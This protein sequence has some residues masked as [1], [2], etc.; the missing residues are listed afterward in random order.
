MM[1][2]GWWWMGWV[3]RVEELSVVLATMML[4]L[5]L[6]YAQLTLNLLF[7]HPCVV[8]AFNFFSYWNICDPA[9][10]RDK[11]SKEGDTH[12]PIS[13]FHLNCQH[14]YENN[15]DTAFCIFSTFW[16]QNCT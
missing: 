12:H 14:A 9:Q 4:V 6:E 7:P 11:S 2:Y 13:D 3:I 1:L 5:L 15:H 16:Y 10:W 8:N